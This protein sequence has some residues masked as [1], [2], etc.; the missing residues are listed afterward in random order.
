IHVDANKNIVYRLRPRENPQAQG[1]YMCDDGRFGFHYINSEHRFIRP[2]ARGEGGLKPTAW[3]QVLPELRQKFKDAVKQDGSS[4]V[5]VLSPFL[6][7][8]EA[9][10]LAKYFKGQSGEVRLALGPVPVV[11]EDD[12]Y[13]KDRKGRAVPLPEAK[14]IIHAEKC[15]NRKG[16]EEILRHFQGEV[17]RFDEVQRWVGAGRVK[18]LY[19]A[20]G[21][22]PRPNGWIGGEAAKTLEKVPLLVVHDLLPSPVSEVAHYIIPAASFAEKDG[23]F[24]NHAQ[25]GQEIRRAIRPP[26]EVRADGQVFLDLM[27]RR[28]LVHA[29]TIRAELAKEVPYFGALASEPGEHGVALASA[30]RA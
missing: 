24:V 13:P 3:E 29:P 5:G 21:Y 26:G 15:P 10:L 4:V 23:V 6:T 7:C 27:E 17:V 19:L 9:Y 28:G 11:G 20:G 12:V 1:W 30:E 8:E 22:P 2:L 18:A 25:L 14:F 16:V